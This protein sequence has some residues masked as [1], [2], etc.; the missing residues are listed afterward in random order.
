MTGT[1]AQIERVKQTIALLDQ[2]IALPNLRAHYIVLKHAKAATLS[3]TLIKFIQSASDLWS[4]DGS[5]PAIVAH[6]ETN[7]LLISSTKRGFEEL[8]RLIA[9]MDVKR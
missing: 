5:I 1:D 3:G 9:E 4:S 8:S 2:A 7:A 6:Q